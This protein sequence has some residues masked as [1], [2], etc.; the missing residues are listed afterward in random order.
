MCWAIRKI[1][2]C[3]WVF[4]AFLIKPYGV[5]NSTDKKIEIETSNCYVLQPKLESNQIPIMYQ[6]LL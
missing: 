6:S 1:F 4:L 3:V 2:Y 5:R